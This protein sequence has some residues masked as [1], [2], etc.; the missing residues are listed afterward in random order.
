MAGNPDKRV[1]EVYDTTLRDGTQAAGFVLSVDDKLKVAQRLDHLGVHYIEGGWPGSNPRDKHFFARAGE[2]RLKTA[3][4]VAFGSTHHA[5]RRPENDQNLAELL[6]AGTDV[7]TMVGKTWDRHVTIQLG[8]PLER[9]LAM[10]ADSVAYLSRHHIQVFFD[11]EHFFDGLKHNREYTLACLKAAAEGGAKC[12]VLCDTNGGSLPG[13]VAEATRLVRQ[14]LP[15]L[16]V[17]VHTHNDAE[18]AVA[19]SLAAVEAGASQVQGT[20]NGVGERCGNANLCSIVAALELK[21][22]LRALPEGRL[23][24]LTDTARF[25][26]ELANQ[27]PR[28]FAPYVGRAAFG[29]KGGLHISA[30]EKDPALYEHVSPEAVGN[31]RRYLISDLAGKAAI[32]RKARDMGLDLAD[33]DPALGRMLEE[34]KAQENKGYVYEAAEASFELLIN[35]VLGRE[36]TY[37]QLMDFRV[38]T[39]KEANNILGCKAPGPVSEATVMVL[40]DGRVRHTAA[41]G[42]GPVNALDRA[43]RKALLGFYP[44]LAEMQ[45]VDYKVRVLSSADGTAARVRVLIESSDGRS[46]WGTVGVSFDV[47]EASWQALAESIQYKLQQ[48]ETS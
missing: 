5:N 43:M 11:A 10:I 20:I 31:D 6:G 17:G 19:N 12:L 3:K 18:L 15:G 8:V 40:V 26:L 21:M 24:L 33:N 23:P 13:Q 29:H 45:L 36:K 34:L 9:N 1:V 35:R 16:A 28:P 46:R 2:L 44:Q 4:L 27:Q 14:T 48:D 7:V 22:G 42:N 41:V 30:V 25:V 37:F 38:H 39:H 47:L 32:L